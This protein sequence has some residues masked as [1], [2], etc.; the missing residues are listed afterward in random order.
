MPHPLYGSGCAGSKTDEKEVSII[1]HVEAGTERSIS[2]PD[3]K[4][5]REHSDDI[6]LYYKDWGPKNAQPIVFHHGWPLS[7]D[8]WDTQMR[9]VVL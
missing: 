9:Y 1:K 5:G 6:E 8:D 4:I 3:I 7:S 2:M